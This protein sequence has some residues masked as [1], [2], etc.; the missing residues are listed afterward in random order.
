MN[1]STLKEMHDKGHPNDMQAVCQFCLFEKPKLPP[2]HEVN[3]HIKA[4]VSVIT[5]DYE[6]KHIKGGEAK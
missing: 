5:D 3:K 6:E 2:A 4:L 1:K